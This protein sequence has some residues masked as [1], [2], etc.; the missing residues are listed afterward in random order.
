[1]I[2]LFEAIGPRRASRIQMAILLGALLL[3]AAQ[4]PAPDPF[5]A[6]V[7]EMYRSR[8]AALLSQYAGPKSKLQEAMELAAKLDEAVVDEISKKLKA[9]PDDVRQAWAKRDRKPRKTGYGDGTWVVLGGQD[10]GLDSA[11][12]GTPRNEK[13]FVDS[14]IDRS[15]S[16]LTKRKPPPPPPPEP[17]PLGKPLKTKDEWW[18]ASSAAERAAFLETDYARKSQAV[19]KKEE[20]KKCAACNGNG[21]V[22]VNRGGLGLTVKCARCHG[23]K[24]DLLVQYQ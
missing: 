3:Q 17:V 10:G 12:K 4:D 7:A 21:T 18:Q 19:E 2:G 24:E 22:N 14:L 20:T 1:M 6:K 5:V 15:P 9:T 8:S 16:V 13:D 23:V 11:A